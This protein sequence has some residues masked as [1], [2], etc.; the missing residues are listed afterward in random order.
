MTAILERYGLDRLN[1]D[2]RRAV[3]DALKRSLP[4]AEQDDEW[5]DWEIELIRERIAASD[6][7]PNGGILLSDL[8]RQ[9]AIPS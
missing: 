7:N 3:M 6:A 5:E 2:E 9:G 1:D 4:E 8:K